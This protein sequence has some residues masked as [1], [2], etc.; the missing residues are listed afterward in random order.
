MNTCVH[1]EHHKRF[2]PYARVYTDNSGEGFTVFTVFTPD[3]VGCSY[4]VAPGL[5]VLVSWRGVKHQ[6]PGRH[7]SYAGQVK[8]TKSLI[9]GYP[10]KIPHP[11]WSLFQFQFVRSVKTAGPHFMPETGGRYGG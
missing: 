1:R 8:R 5:G 6:C 4:D 7:Q 10:G 3:G 11:I 2:P 9:F